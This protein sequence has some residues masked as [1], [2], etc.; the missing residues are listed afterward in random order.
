[1]SYDIYKKRKLNYAFFKKIYIAIL[2][3]VT[4]P[5][6]CDRKKMKLHLENYLKSVKTAFIKIIVHFIAPYILASRISSE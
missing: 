4:I 6:C 1:M 5:N 2:L 3:R